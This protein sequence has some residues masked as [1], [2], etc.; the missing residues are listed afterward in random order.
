MGEIGATRMLGSIDPDKLPEAPPD[1][2]A[3]PEDALRTPSG[4]ASRVLQ[5][6]AGGGDLPLPGE[7]DEDVAVGGKGADR[8]GDAVLEISS[9][10]K[11]RLAGRVYDL[12]GEGTPL[13][14]EM[15]AADGAR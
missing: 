2:A 12:D 10:G 15:G 14:L 1:V 11:R 13:A 5:P 7:E 3:P 6:G 4:L 8:V 9:I